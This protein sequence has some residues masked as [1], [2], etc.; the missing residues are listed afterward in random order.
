MVLL[1]SGNLDCQLNAR[2]E[3]VAE[4]PID[5]GL[6]KRRLSL[7]PC[8]GFYE[9]RWEG[10]GKIHR[11]IRPTDCPPIWRGIK[12]KLH[13]DYR[14]GQNGEQVSAQCLSV[15]LHPDWT[16]YLRLIM[17]RVNRAK[18]FETQNVGS[19]LVGQLSNAITS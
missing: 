15:E 11:H 7:I 17:N 1:L 19:H 16:H 9:W 5:C 14:G 18:T 6:L 4:N 8:T 13:S 10:G 2:A 12:S 3:T